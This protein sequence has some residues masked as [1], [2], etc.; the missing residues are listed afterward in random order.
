MYT[1]LGISFVTETCRLFPFEMDL[2]H[3]LIKCYKTANVSKTEGFM[4]TTS[5]TAYLLRSSILFIGF[6]NFV[7]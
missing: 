3:N 6:K 4:C 7:W 5:K 2:A 1:L